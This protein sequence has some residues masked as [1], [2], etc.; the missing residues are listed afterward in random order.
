M[1]PRAPSLTF[2]AALWA[3]LLTA[4]NTWAAESFSPY[5]DGEGTISLPEGYL[6]WTRLG[7]WS[8]AGEEPGAGAKAFHVVYTQP[9]TVAAYRET[10]QIP[11]GAVLVKEL[12]DTVTEELSTGRVS[13]A[14][15]VTGWFVMVKGAK[16]R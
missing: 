13:R 10:G 2:A 5:V 9:E 11:D 7:T 6:G 15:A 1:P 4:A 14:K 12:M 16:G 3:A 8:I